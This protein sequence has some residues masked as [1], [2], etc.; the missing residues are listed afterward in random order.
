MTTVSSKDS[1]GG[2]ERMG[3]WLYLT[4]VLVLLVL[5]GCT[6]NPVKPNDPRFAPVAGNTLRPP[7][8]SNGAIFQDGFATNLWE[9]QRAKRTGDIITVILQESTSASKT[10]STS[11]SKDSTT[12]LPNPTIFGSSPSF[13]AGKLLPGSSSNLSL[14]QDFDSQ[15]SFEGEADADQSNNLTGNITVTVSE[16]LPNGVLVVRGEKWL[17]L[18]Q[19]E[20]Y[21]RISGLIRPADIAPDNTIQSNKIADARITYAGRGELANS[22]RMGWVARFFNSDYWPF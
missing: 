2:K 8:P 22:G 9:D 14:A 21:I 17:T 5:T 18:A 4:I 13:D 6:Q 20:E 16:V 3:N 10:N 19:G 1:G 11:I 7:A 12:A 15:S